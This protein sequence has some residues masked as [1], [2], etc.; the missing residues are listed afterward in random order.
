MP[1]RN[2]E[3]LTLSRGVYRDANTFDGY[4]AFKVI[5]S[6]GGLIISSCVRSDMVTLELEDTLWHWLEERDPRVLKLA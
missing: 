4:V 1:Q 6:D 2:T 3:I 5:G